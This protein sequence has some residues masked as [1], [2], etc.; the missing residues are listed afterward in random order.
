MSGPNTNIPSFRLFDGDL[1]FN[2]G[3]DSQ[4]DPSKLIPGQYC[5]GINI[6]NR[7]GIAQCRPGYRC[8]QA[9]PE[10]NLQGFS[11]FSPKLGNPVMLLAVE[12]SADVSFSDIARQIFFKQVEQ[13]VIQNPDGSLTFIDSRQLMIMQDGGF[14]PPVIYDGTSSTHTTAIPLGGPMEWTG[15]RLWVARDSKL[16]ASDI[17]NPTSFTEPLYIAGTPF[18]QLPGTITALAKTPGLAE[19][20]LLVFTEK[21]TSLIQSNIRDRASWAVTPNFQRPL[22]ANVG[23][24]ANRSVV[25]HWGMLWWFSEYGLTNFDAAQQAFI[26]SKLPYSDGPMADSKAR[27]SE[28]VSGIAGIS[29]ENYLLLSVP[30]CDK[31][32]RHTWCLDQNAVE[33]LKGEVPQ[34]WNSVWTGTR[35][36]EWAQATVNGFPQV[37]HI[38]VDRCGCNTLWE[39]FQPDRLDNGCEITWALETRAYPGTDPLT[40]KQIRFADIFLSELLGEFDLAVFWAGGKRGRYKRVLTKRIQ[41]TR[42]PIRYND[43]YRLHDRL[44]SYK[45]QSR[46][47]RT[48]DARELWPNEELTSCGVERSIDGAEFIDESFQLLIVGS[49]PGAVDAVKLFI[50]PEGGDKLS[51]ACEEDEV[52]IRACRFDGA[53]EHGTNFHSVLEEL[54]QDAL[55]FRSSRTATITVDDETQIGVGEA[56]SIISQ[57]DADKVAQHIAN[58]VASKRL[59]AILPSAVSRLG[60]FPTIL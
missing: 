55:P 57:D 45:K 18:F 50:D 8:K 15:D 49:G 7:G 37:F 52:D 47:V 28:D 10:G 5:R 39:A 4:Q 24:V 34:L 6:V 29:V 3:Q 21:T 9:L 31:F 36:V 35:P 56:Q 19:E 32:N 23:C 42:G 54:S 11:F 26:T 44:Y 40:G 12:G 59:E 58:R 2:Y 41:A 46:K 33:S 22:F 60:G 53:C 16:F 17:A 25:Q 20:R 14:T 13:S 27:L 38:S 43:T 30:Y 51:G 1:S 48:Q